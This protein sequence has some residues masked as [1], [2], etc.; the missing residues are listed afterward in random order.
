MPINADYFYQKAEQEFLL[1]K[2]LEEKI[3]K[4]Q[5]MISAA[6]KH[7][8]SEKLRAELTKRLVKLKKEAEKAKKK[9]KSYGIKKEGDAR[10]VI[11][12]KT[13]SGKSSLLSVLTNAKPRISNIPFTTFKPEIGTMDLEGIKIQLIEIPSRLKDKEMLAI[14]RSSDLIPVSY[15]H[16]TLPTN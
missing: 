1:A 13:Q 10:V 6:P 3:K 11:F 5:K 2:T 16:L 12:G 14:V 7:K 8:G 15:T 9:G 4:L